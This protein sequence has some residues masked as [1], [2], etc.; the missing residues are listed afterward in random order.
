MVQSGRESR[1]CGKVEGLLLRVFTLGSLSHSQA[2]RLHRV[3]R[4]S[5]PATLQTPKSLP[6]F[7]PRFLPELYLWSKLIPLNCLFHIS[8]DQLWGNKPALLAPG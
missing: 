3:A 5:P 2:A 4:E 7:P 1:H 6:F 8:C